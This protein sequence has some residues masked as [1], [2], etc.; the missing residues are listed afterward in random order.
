MS[1]NGN[2]SLPPSLHVY[3]ITT[4][5]RELPP[6]P[7]AD[8][9]RCKKPPCLQRDTPEPA[10]GRAARETAEGGRQ[11]KEAPEPREE[12][13]DSGELHAGGPQVKV[14]LGPLHTSPLFPPPASEVAAAQTQPSS[15][16]IRSAR[17]PRNVAVA[18]P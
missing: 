8:M 12:A 17:T 2:C 7:T 3:V 9:R 5:Q 6:R 11:W 10:L 14:G 16:V 4:S 1:C 13:E 15:M 18:T